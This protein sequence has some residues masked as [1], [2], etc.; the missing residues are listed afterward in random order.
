VPSSTLSISSDGFAFLATLSG[1][2]TRPSPS[3]VG[4]SKDRRTLPVVEG[5]A[6]YAVRD[7]PA[8]SG[9]VRRHIKRGFTND[10]QVAD[11]Y[12][13]KSKITASKDAEDA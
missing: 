2:P 5:A 4:F 11:D 12:A 13:V 10:Y 1:N 9:T 8:V 3:W 7:I 6:T